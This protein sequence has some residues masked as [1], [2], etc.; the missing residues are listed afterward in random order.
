[1]WILASTPLA[2]APAAPRSARGLPPLDR[3]EPQ[4]ISPTPLASTEPAFTEI[5]SALPVHDLAKARITDPSKSREASK[6]LG[7]CAWSGSVLST[8]LHL[9]TVTGAS[10]G[11]ALH[12]V[13][14]RLD[15]AK[16]AGAAYSLTLRWPIRAA[17]TLPSDALPLHPTGKVPIVA[18]HVWL[19]TYHELGAHS[20]Q[21]DTAVAHVEFPESEQPTRFEKRLRCDEL[22]LSIS[23]NDDA[24]LPLGDSRTS[25]T[26]VD[27]FTAPD[28]KRVARHGGMFSVT[29]RK[30]RWARIFGRFPYAHD[31]WVHADELNEPE[32]G[33][34]AIGYFGENTHPDVRIT[35]DLEFRMTPSKDAPV[36]G[37]I[38]RDAEVIIGESEDGFTPLQV[39]GLFGYTK[40]PV[41][42]VERAALDVSAKRIE[43][44]Q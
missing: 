23:A 22:A 25:R 33:F 7:G 35:A 39:A 42:Y 29:E 30:G 12:V 36:Q 19:D 28:G 41:F 5:R 40:M 13:V 14:D 4:A 8:G 1:M 43:A 38:V 32:G 3:K 27:I 31:G 15:A 20:P 18:G 2:C 37:T 6:H 16:G 26:S 34:Y 24:R 21:A 11:I 10:L 17:A 9:S 44:N